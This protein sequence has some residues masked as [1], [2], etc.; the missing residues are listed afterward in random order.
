M[1]ASVSAPYIVSNIKAAAQP[2][3]ATGSRPVGCCKSDLA[4]WVQELDKY[5]TPYAPMYCDG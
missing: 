4:P 1:P 3:E 2:G 5:V